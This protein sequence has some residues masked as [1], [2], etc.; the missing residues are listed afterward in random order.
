MNSAMFYGRTS[1]ET[2]N[3]SSESDISCNSSDE[4]KPSSYETDDANSSKPGSE[5]ESDEETNNDVV[6]P[7]SASAVFGNWV[8]SPCCSA[9]ATG[10]RRGGASPP[11]KTACVPSE[12]KILVLFWKS[13]FGKFWKSFFGN[14][15]LVHSECF[16]EHRVA[17]RQQAIMEKRI[18]TF[19]NNSR[20]N[21][22]RLEVRL[23]ATNCST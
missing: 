19:K 10:G 6:P 13:H 20:L 21:F 18:I 2:K 15:I 12:W 8:L 11:L 23:P 1:S 14:P 5:S 22:S 7:L 9:V 3:N 17:T 16:L 4:Y